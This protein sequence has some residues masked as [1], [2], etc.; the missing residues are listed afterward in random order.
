MPDVG[1]QG[2]PATLR[3]LISNDRLGYETGLHGA[4]RFLI[5]ATQALLHRGIEVTPVVLRVSEGIADRPPCVDD[6]PFV[7][8]KRH[9][10]D[11]RTITD[12]VRLIR[13]RGIQLVHLQGYGASTFGRLAALRCGIPSLVHVHADYR[14]AQKGYS[15]YVREMDRL[16][17]RSTPL[18]LAVSSQV[19]EFAIEAQGFD[20]TTVTVLH[21]PVDRSVFRAPSKPE[22]AKARRELGIG[23]EDKVAVFVGRLDHLKG[24]DVLLAAWSRVVGRVQDARLLIVGGGPLEASLRGEA[25]RSSPASSVVFTGHREDVLTL[26]WAADLAVMASRHEGLPLAVLEAMATDIPVVATR[27]GGLPEIIQDGVN[28]ALVPSE[29][30]VALADTLV[31]LLTNDSQRQTL[32]LGAHST[33]REHDL[34]EYAKRLESIYRTLVE[35]SAT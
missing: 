35:P 13:D 34:N 23:P 33:A 4:G 3:V 15:W 24:V 29:D 12:L 27:V 21:N 5:W 2:P 26:L 1:A 20:P 30:P 7:F 14:L 8:L 11:P 22:K 17:A 9:E 18:A 25:Q 32:A 10:F 19:R 16:L 31:Q 28:G 6:L